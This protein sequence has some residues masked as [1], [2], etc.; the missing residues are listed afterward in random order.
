VTYDTAL[1]SMYESKIRY[2]LLSALNSEKIRLDL[3]YKMSLH[4]N[5]LQD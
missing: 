1:Q 3:T 2:F 5:A 4:V